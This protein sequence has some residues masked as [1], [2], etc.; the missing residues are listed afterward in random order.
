MTT[1]RPE[2]LRG[3]IQIGQ[4]EGVADE[5]GEDR[6]GGGEKERGNTSRIGVAIN[7]PG[8]R[9]H[10]RRR[11]RIE[12]PSSS[13]AEGATPATAPCGLARPTAIAPVSAPRHDRAGGVEDAGHETTG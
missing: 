11:S 8:I 1:A 9:S 5:A 6:V 12:R 3:R 4:V 10:G 7:R 13:G 2:V